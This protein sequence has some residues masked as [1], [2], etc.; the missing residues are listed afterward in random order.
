MVRNKSADM[1]ISNGIDI[2]VLGSSMV[3]SF[4]LRHLHR[5]YLYRDSQDVPYTCVLERED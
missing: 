4:D 1:L 2:H 5:R 3:A